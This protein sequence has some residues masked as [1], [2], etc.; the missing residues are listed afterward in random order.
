MATKQSGETFTI[1]I[2]TI[3]LLE[4]RFEDATSHNK[5]IMLATFRKIRKLRQRPAHALLDDDRFDQKFRKDQRALIQDAYFAVRT[6]RSLLETHLGIEHEVPE[7]L[8]DG[9]HW[10]E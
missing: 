4:R 10:V 3:R 1:T 2:L 5:D 6:I 7:W 9:G 8:S